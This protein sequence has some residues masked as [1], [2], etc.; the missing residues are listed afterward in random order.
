MQA[1]V[2][3]CSGR[4]PLKL[5]PKLL[6]RPRNRSRTLKTAYVKSLR[7]R[8]RSLAQLPKQNRPDCPPNPKLDHQLAKLPHPLSSKSLLSNFVFRTSTNKLG[9]TTSSAN[10]CAPYHQ[11]ILD[12]TTMKASLKPASLW[13]QSRSQ[14]WLAAYHRLIRT[15]KNSA[16][17]LVP[18]SLS[19]ETS[20]S[21][22]TNRT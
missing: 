18:A 6:K 14:T 22:N 5:S 3:H 17:A 2:A 8:K 10:A 12:G 11:N 13:D 4:I 1:V 21:K 19:I 16:S 7:Y 20:K 9:H 15:K